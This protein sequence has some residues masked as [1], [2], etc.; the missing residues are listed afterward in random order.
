MMRRFHMLI[1]PVMRDAP[2]PVRLFRL[3]CLT[4][5][6]LC[7]GIVLPA[8]LLQNLSIW[9]H[10]G[11]VVLGL[12]GLA[13]LRASMQGR[14]RFR[15]FLVAMVLLMNS[16]WFANAG[17]A[18]SVTYYYFAL[19]LYP[20]ALFRGGWRWSLTALVVLNVVGLLVVEFFFPELVVGF[21]RPL[22]R[23]I[24]LVSGIVCASLA[25][26]LVIWV[27][28]EAHDREH[29]RLSAVADE[30]TASE[31]NY[32]E[33][34]NATS[35]A[36]F[37]HEENGRL[38]D[39]NERACAEFGYT[40]EEAL[41]LAVGELS[42]GARPYGAA[43][44]Q[45][46]VALALTAGPQVFTWRSR[47]KNGE[48]FWSE[49]ALRA[50]DLG[51]RR[52]VIAAVRNIDDRVKAES[53]LRLNEER[54]R[55][56]LE[57]SHQ[58]WF[59]LNL[60][61]GEGTASAE[62]ARII[63]REPVDFRVTA[64]SWLEGLHPDDREQVRQAFRECAETGATRSMEYRRRSVH[65]DWK[66][67]RSIGKVVEFDSA[68]RPARMMGTHT[69]ITERKE[70]EAKLEQS[71][72]LEAV[73][74]LAGGVAHDLNNILTPI[75]MASD[76]LREKLPTDSDRELMTMLEQG[77]RRGAAI[78]RQLLTFSRGVA[79]ARAS[80]DVGA[81][82]RECAR[83]LRSSWPAEWVVV[84]RV[85]PELW[86]VTADAGQLQQALAN[87]CANAHEAM[88]GGGVLTLSAENVELDD[89]VT[90]R[91]PWG[92]A[93]RFVAITVSDTGRG[94]TPEVARR[95]F[96]PFF[97]T[98]EIGQ[99]PG[100]GLSVVHGIVRDHGGSITMAAEVGRGTTFRV[101]LPAE[102]EH[103]PKA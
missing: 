22:D 58:G 18:G 57:A 7:L 37:I 15:G 72:R 62:Y 35:D 4:T 6:G 80:V 63:G 78:V 82:I 98:K 79:Q 28:L 12:I 47:R 46:K 39:L 97:T 54:L 94:V 69:D 67:I 26:I 91:N 45:A 83:S 41:A 50:S 34:F 76:V 60:R 102:R 42:L 89:G 101:I 86:R 49:V 27:I 19:A 2:L 85:A 25:V 96:D 8:N 16:V 5:S 52:R 9:V 68:G 88:P 103:A 14:H 36:L 30:L 87:L 65:G 17:S 81:L 74:T 3:L 1:E 31:R 20:M 48:L 40:R 90:S 56:A 29:G 59:D 10:V 77:A 13:C 70:L 71:R 24:D 23:L 43:E 33:I 53:A 66:W 99:G 44:A 73:G 92:K 11:N 84:E 55:L 21:V 51:G 61:T 38:V 64:Q 100:L 93:G 95:V 75:L 32:R